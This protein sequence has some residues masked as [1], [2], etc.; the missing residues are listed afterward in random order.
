ML[1][2]RI[3][4]GLGLAAS[5]TMMG[6]RAHAAEWDPAYHSFK[7]VYTGLC[8]SGSDRTVNQVTC[9]LPV[10]GGTRSTDWTLGKTASGTLIKNLPTGLC[11]DTNGADVYLSGCTA[12]DT[13][14]LWTVANYGGI[15]GVWPS[16]IIG[17]SLTGWN[18]G[19]V[20][21]AKTSDVD[22]GTKFRWFYQ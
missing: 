5:L 8:L 7:N 13:G 15:V 19:G 4:A 10:S 2:A 9:G 18:S 16:Q 20:S 22:M 1:K 6:S 21:V 17:H 12:S 14:Q 11:L 3:M